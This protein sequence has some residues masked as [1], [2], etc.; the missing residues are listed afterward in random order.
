MKIIKQEVTE[1]KDQLLIW[2]SLFGGDIIEDRLQ[3]DCGRIDSYNFDF[4][5]LFIFHIQFTEEVTVKRILLP[6]KYYPILFS[7]SL[8]FEPYG[9]MGTKARV[10]KSAITGVFFSN[11]SDQITYPAHVPFTLIVFRLKEKSFLEFV[12]PE[13]SFFERIHEEQYFIY[14]MLTVEMKLSYDAILQNKGISKTDKNILYAHGLILLSLFAQEADLRKNLKSSKLDNQ[15]RLVIIRIKNLI[16]QDLSVPIDM[17]YLV[18]F[19]GMSETYIRMYFKDV[20]GMS[21]NSFYQYYRIEYAKELLITTNLS[22]SEIAFRLGYSHLGHFI[23]IFKRQY[24][25]TPK[26]LQKMLESD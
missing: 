3:G 26:K 4:F 17:N 14:E 10:D 16:L 11:A 22:V 18:K 6:E 7:D 20:F 5:E 15:K 13:S 1:L 25:V 8:V 9:E 21:I 19:A 2:K 23:K 24:G 12:S